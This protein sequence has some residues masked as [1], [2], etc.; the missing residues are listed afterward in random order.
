MKQLP[1]SNFRCFATRRTTPKIKRK[2]HCFSNFATTC[3]K[4]P[5]NAQPAST[6][7]ARKNPRQTIGDKVINMQLQSGRSR[8]VHKYG[9][10]RRTTPK[11]KR[12]I[13]YHRS[14]FATNCKKVSAN[15]QPASTAF[16]RKNPRQT[17]G[18]KVINM[19][20]QSGRSRF[21]HKYGATRRTTP[22]IKTKIHY[23]RSNFTT[24]CTEML[25]NTQSA[26]TVFAR[27]IPDKLSGT[28]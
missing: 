19:Q 15:A 24:T 8:F 27:K 26:L 3:T 17:I 22:K 18:D 4:V 7:F 14:N 10:T 20:L 28:K 12:K 1:K 23:H 6:A 25:A 16:A 13:H 2:I 21:V 5:A 9:A 11:I